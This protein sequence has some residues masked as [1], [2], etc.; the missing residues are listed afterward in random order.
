MNCCTPIARDTGRLFSG[1]ARWDRL[2]FRTLGFEKTQRRMIEGLDGAGLE[3][4]TLLEIGCGSSYLHQ[5]LLRDHG[6]SR[7]T[8][9]DLSAG[10][11][12]LAREAAA[13]GGLSG[14]VDYRLGDF[15]QIADS[16]PD[17]DVT[18]LD[19]VICCYPDWKALIDCTIGKTRRLC[20]LTYPRDRSITRAGVR[21]MRWAIQL[22][23]C[24][25]QPFIHEPGKIQARVRDHGFRLYSDALTTGW[26]TQVY[27]NTRA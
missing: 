13:A 18:I 1:V 23:G 27:V 5:A 20:A 9:V 7:A 26:I 8:G 17:A 4:S 3:G 11:L 10:M 6:A 24:R 19:K 25:Y 12:A 14:R 16:L 21:I 2:R 22:S 15:V